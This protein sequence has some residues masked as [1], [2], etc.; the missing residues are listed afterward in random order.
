MA[1]G[2]M[3]GP[4]KRD[5]EIRFVGGSPDSRLVASLG[6]GP[7]VTTTDGFVPHRQ[8]LKHMAESA[9]LLLIVRRELPRRAGAM[10]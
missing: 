6:L 10:S 1:K 2:L 4:G 9:V 3:H 7:M 5:L 8:A